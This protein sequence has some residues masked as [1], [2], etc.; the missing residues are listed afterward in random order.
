L[1]HEAFI[2]SSDDE[3]ADVLAP[4]LA[5][6]AAGGQAAVAVTSPERARLLREALGADRTSVSFFEPEQWYSRPGATLSAWRDTLDGYPGA[7]TLRVIGEIPFGGDTAT[8][9]RWMSYESLFNRAFADR[10]AWVVCAYDTRTLTKQIVADARRTHPVVSTGAGRAPSPEHFAGHELGA[11]LSPSVAR[12]NVRF[13]ATTTVAGNSDPIELRRVVTWAARS[14]GISEDVVE[15]LVLAIGEVARASAG[16]TVRTGE[17]GG[18]WFC[19]VTATGRASSEL[20]LDENGLGVLIGRL[21]CDSVEIDQ[22]K[23]R[24]LV[25]FVFGRPRVSPR[26]RILGAG[27]ELFARNGVRATGVDAIIARAGVAKGTFYAHFPSKN[28]LVLAWLQSSSVQWFDGV[29]AEVEAR[30]ATPAE[31]LALFFD[32]L[33]EWLAAD[34][35]RGCQTLNTAAE[36]H[37]ADPARQ[38]LAELQGEIEEYLRLA[39]TD[40]GL[41]DADRLASQ[42]LLLVAGT[43]TTATTRRSTEPATAARLAAARLVASAQR[44]RP[45]E[46]GQP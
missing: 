46:D 14:S 42:L 30:A 43:I 24:Q 15:D 36:A 22:S 5:E 32:V 35:F 28:E 19:E 40:A 39:A 20:P 17:A 13:G 23:G 41:P 26:E 16:A 44:R 7:Q 2:Y 29:R 1:I 4:F 31:R 45:S 37:F 33:G 12:A 27:A 3:Y 21:I 11:S 10:A 9:A 6:A 18:E 38:A 8:D 25:R 34:E